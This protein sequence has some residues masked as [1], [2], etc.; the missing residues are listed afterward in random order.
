MESEVLFEMV[1]EL[2]RGFPDIKTPDDVDLSDVPEGDRVFATLPLMPLN[3]RSRNGRSYPESVVRDVVRQINEERPVGN[4]GHIPEHLR[5]THHEPAAIRWIAAEIKDGMAWGKFVATR[6]DARED[7]L[8]AKRTKGR[9][10]TSIYGTAEYNGETVARVVLES[11]DLGSPQ[12]LGIPEAAAR[13][14]VTAEMMEGDS[15]MEQVAELTRQRDG[16]Q[17]QVATLTARAAEL[18]QR[19]TAY[20][21]VVAETD[22]IKTRAAELEAQVAEYEREVQEFRTLK[23]R[24]LN[25]QI[26]DAVAEAVK[27][28]ALR[29]LVRGMVAGAESIETARTR[30][31]EIVGSEFYKAAAEKIVQ[32]EMGPSAV[33]PP[34]PPVKDGVDMSP[35]AVRMAREKHGI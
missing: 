8:W 7:V 14:L 25:R 33:V 15:D 1:S 10:G 29:P 3:A 5:S 11:I 30:I 12:R 22:A 17:E 34:K 32:A 13:P 21:Q 28:D 27:V 23:A 19:V 18:E 24:D 4:Y 16:L 26:D 20:E 9:L 6:A 2:K 35:D 31:A